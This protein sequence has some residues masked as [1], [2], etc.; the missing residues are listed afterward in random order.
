MKKSIKY[1]TISIIC[2][3]FLLIVTVVLL[4]VFINEQRYVPAIEQKIS[5]ITGRSFS[6][7]S[8][9]DISYFPWLTI[10]F[11][12]LKLGNPEGFSTD[13]FFTVES[14]EAQVELLSLLFGQIHVRRFVLGG[15]EVNM[16][17]TN[18]GKEN[19]LL[20]KN[21]DQLVPLQAQSDSGLGVLYEN[22][23]IA[24]FAVTDAKI[25]VKDQIRQTEYHIDDVMLL[26]T[27]VSLD[28]SFATEIKALIGGKPVAMEG[29]IGPFG[30]KPGI[31]PV[32][33]DIRLV[34][35][36]VL[37][38]SIRG[39]F[40]KLH[41]SPSY[42]LNMHVEPFSPRYLCDILDVGF[43]I[44]IASPETYDSLSLDMTV[45]GNM[46]AIRV[47]QGD[48]MLD[49]TRIKFAFTAKNFDRP[50]VTF[51]VDLD[52]V[53]LEHYFFID[54]VDDSVNRSKVNDYTIWRD[55]SITGRLA[56]QT[57]TFNGGN[58]HDIRA[59]L[60]GNNGI[61]TIDPSLFSINNGQVQSTIKINVQKEVPEITVSVQS[62]NIILGEFLNDFT[63][64]DCI[65]GILTGEMKADFTGFDFESIKKTLDGQGTFVL[66]N[67][68]LHGIDLQGKT[69]ENSF[70]DYS[71]I[72]SVFTVK[73]GVFTL[74]D[75]R[76]LAPAGQILVSGSVDLATDEINF[77]MKP[78]VVNPDKEPDISGNGLQSL[79]LVTGTLFSPVAVVDKQNVSV[80]G[81]QPANKVNV[82]KLVD[83]KIPSPVDDDVKGLVGKA[84]ID[85]EIVA[86]R[87]GLQPVT[88]KSLK[89]KKVFPVGRGKIEIRQLLEEDVFHDLQDRTN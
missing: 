49:N 80:E 33:V 41:S 69:T 81:L 9:L 42:E 48:A 25:G 32:A 74:Q 20:S 29:S 12:D 3:L 47:E 73:D 82:Q 14:F 55:V 36:N 17:R 70:V 4:P 84:L 11:S 8:D 51:D 66:Q 53:D 89:R 71:Q 1:S 56:L 31:E 37:K 78:S 13:E 87:F 5:D 45:K 34:L 7:G 38:T 18:D 15:L 85:P 65:T 62:K 50:V 2:F 46:S 68:V 75:T 79:M 52:S 39:K 64:K 22:M 83:D 24:L 61:F 58:L 10:S 28:K 63:N 21:S 44:P 27:D 35:A 6:I 59:N 16:E 43:P 30:R 19:W 57:L 76:L 23:N 26:A 77:K 40:S 60:N 67:G 88:I 54:T 72:N 86:R